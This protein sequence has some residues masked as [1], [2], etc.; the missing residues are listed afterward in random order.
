MEKNTPILVCLEAELD[1]TEEGSSS[2]YLST[3]LTGI[4]GLGSQPFSTLKQNSCQD[5][6]QEQDA[7]TDITNGKV[8]TIPHRPCAVCHSSLKESKD[9]TS[10]Y[11]KSNPLYLLRHG[12]L[13][14]LFVSRRTLKLSLPEEVPTSFLIS[15]L[16]K[17]FP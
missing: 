9:G 13:G 12:H 3:R 11:S 14:T 8:R 6:E 16:T 5:R 17:C 7:M 15:S 4:N 1:D 10:R 2:V